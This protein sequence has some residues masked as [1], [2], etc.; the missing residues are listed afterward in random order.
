[1][2]LQ[3]LFA[4]V[5]CIRLRNSS[6]QRRSKTKKEFIFFFVFVWVC[7]R[8]KSNLNSSAKMHQL[9]WD[10]ARNS[11]KTCN[12]C[13]LIVV[14]MIKT[15]DYLRMDF[16]FYDQPM[17]VVLFSHLS[18]LCFNLGFVFNSNDT[19]WKKK[20]IL[21]CGRREWVLKKKK[22]TNGRD[23]L[24]DEE[25]KTF[26]LNQ[27]QRSCR[28]TIKWQFGEGLCI[29]LLYSEVVNKN[30]ETMT[31]P[32]INATSQRQPRMIWALLRFDFDVLFQHL[33]SVACVFALFAPF[34]IAFDTMLHKCEKNNKKKMFRCQPLIALWKLIFSVNLF[35]SNAQEFHSRSCKASR[36][37]DIRKKERCVNKIW[38][39]HDYSKCASCCHFAEGNPTKCTHKKYIKLSEF[40]TDVAK[41][42]QKKICEKIFSIH[43]K[44]QEIRYSNYHFDMNKKNG[45]EITFKKKFMHPFI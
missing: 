20:I 16:R 36:Q 9:P 25:K 5:V 29:Y 7:V 27:K 38:F 11:S 6:T 24:S 21:K 2:R 3:K 26:A 4:C 42:L 41:N 18:I 43:K 30:D 44:C 19:N 1:M 10:Q 12:L 45:K 8:D 35:L 37:N 14:E 31:Y 40:E 17:M 22:S 34:W 23:S 39:L 28:K 15:H 13:L 33:V 32:T